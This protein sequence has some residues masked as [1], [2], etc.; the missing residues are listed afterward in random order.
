MIVASQFVLF[1]IWFWAATSKLTHHF[2]NVVAVMVSNT[3]WNRF[4]AIKRRLYRNHPEDLRPSRQATYFAHLGTFIEFAFPLLLILSQGGTL[5]WIA[6]GAMVVFHIHITSTFPLAVPLEWNLFMIFGTIFLFGHYGDVPL[7]T[8]D[9]P[10]LIAIMAVVLVFI[11]FLGNVRPDLIA[12]LPAMRYYAGNWATTQWL[13]RDDAGAEETLD[14]NMV[15]SSPV[16]VKQLTT[17]YDEDAAELTL[18]KALAFRALHNHGRALNGL[19]F[20]AVDNLD[21][22][23]VREGEFLAGALIGWN[24]GD[25]HWHG[26]Q[27]LDVVQERCNF[28]P[29]ELRVVTMESQPIHKQ[30]QHYKIYDAAT[31]LIEEGDVLVRDMM[32]R[33]PWLDLKGEFPVQVAGRPRTVPEPPPQAAHV[34]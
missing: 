17:L 6:V 34:T 10:L 5:G 22:Y 14:Q 29:G 32:D 26:K 23:T 33:Q 28:A 25:G 16:V 21:D 4:P 20:R 11:P 12:F 19:L 30:Q 3:P 15:K 7:N 1:F 24:F 18:S 27:L 31:G 2:T 8:L 9:D 13:F